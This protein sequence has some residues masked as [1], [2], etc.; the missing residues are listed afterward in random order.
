V[1]DLSLAFCYSFDEK[2]LAEPEPAGKFLVIESDRANQYTSQDLIG[3]G[4]LT[5][6]P[7]SAPDSA[8]FKANTTVWHP[9]TGNTYTLELDFVPNQDQGGGGD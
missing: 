3:A 5:D 7:N 6:P 8:C 9:T 4:T 1:R 2:L